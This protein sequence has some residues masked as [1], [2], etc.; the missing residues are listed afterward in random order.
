MIEALGKCSVR[1]SV[2][3]MASKSRVKSLFGRAQG[4]STVSTP[5]SGHFVQELGHDRLNQ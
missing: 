5:Q 1:A 4:T 2:R 3:I